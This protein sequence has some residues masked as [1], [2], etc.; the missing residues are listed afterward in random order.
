MKYSET[1]FRPLYAFEIRGRPERT[2][3]VGKG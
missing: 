2:G 3:A 1:G